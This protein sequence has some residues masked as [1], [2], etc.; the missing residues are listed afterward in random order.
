MET[1]GLVTSPWSDY[2][3][4]ASPRDMLPRLLIHSLTVVSQHDPSSKSSQCPGRWDKRGASRRKLPNSSAEP[5][6]SASPSRPPRYHA[7]RQAA[8]ARSRGEYQWDVH[9]IIEDRRRTPI[10]GPSTSISK[11]HISPPSPVA[12][13][14]GPPWVSLS[15]WAFGH[16]EA[17]CYRPWLVRR[18]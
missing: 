13:S 15:E 16:A 2:A 12:A 3:A 7:A 4:Q 17:A 6:E 18:H 9:E 10:T 5:I 14:R 11:C 1:R 8:T